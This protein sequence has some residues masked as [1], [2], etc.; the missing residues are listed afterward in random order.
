MYTVRTLAAASAFILGGTAV[1]EIKYY[2]KVSFCVAEDDN[3]EIADDTLFKALEKEDSECGGLK[4]FNLMNIADKRQC[5]V[6]VDDG[7]DGEISANP[8][9]VF[10][11]KEKISSSEW[12]CD[13]YEVKKHPVH[14]TSWTVRI[15]QTVQEEI[16]EAVSKRKHDDILE[17]AYKAVRESA[18]KEWKGLPQYRAYAREHSLY[19]EKHW[20]HDVGADKGSISIDF[21]VLITTFALA[22]LFIFLF[23]FDCNKFALYKRLFHGSHDDSMDKLP[24]NEQALLAAAMAGEAQSG[25]SPTLTADALDQSEPSDP[26]TREREARMKAQETKDSAESKDD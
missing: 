10:C 22:P 9:D 4:G 6:S 17:N 3:G 24:E 19:D 16:D 8:M 1:N 21:I 25:S 2:I 15:A 5:S 14:K 26:T 20:A 7:N 23:F 11:P 18:T 12:E 13:I